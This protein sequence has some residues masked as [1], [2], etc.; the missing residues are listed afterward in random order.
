MARSWLYL[1]AT[2]SVVALSGCQVGQLPDLKQYNPFKAAADAA[3]E[4]DAKAE[5]VSD[6]VPSL[7]SLIAAADANVNV[8]AGFASAMKSALASDPYVLSAKSDAAALK[9]RVRTT[10]SQK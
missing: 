6:E 7:A 10:T 9:A 5:D 8:D 1:I 3:S 2:T 4:T